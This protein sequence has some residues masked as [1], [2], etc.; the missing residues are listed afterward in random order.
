MAGDPITSISELVREVFGFAV[1]SNT[2][3]QMSRKDKLAKWA[4]A[5][6]EALDRNDMARCDAILNVMRDFRQQTG[7]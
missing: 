7:P 2:Y 1:G 4:E 3:E 6:N 5:Y